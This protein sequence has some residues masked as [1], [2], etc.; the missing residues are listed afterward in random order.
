MEDEQILRN[1]RIGETHVVGSGKY[2]R[3]IGGWIYSNCLG[4]SLVFIPETEQGF[5]KTIIKKSGDKKVVEK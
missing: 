1:L 3:A 5:E 4:G 2:T